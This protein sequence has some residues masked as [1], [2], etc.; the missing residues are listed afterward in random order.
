MPSRPGFKDPVAPS[1]SATMSA[2]VLRLRPRGTASADDRLALTICLAIIVHAM[3]VLGVSFSPTPRPDAGIETMDILLVSEQSAAAPKDADMLAQANLE[4]GGESESDTPPSAPLRAPLPSPVAAIAATPPPP[5]AARAAPAAEL[6][7]PAPPSPTAIPA[8]PVDA[9]TPV[10]SRVTRKTETATEAAAEE[11]REAPTAASPVPADVADSTIPA[12]PVDSIPLP[13]AAQLLTRSFALASVNA[14]L[15]QRLDSRAHRPRQKYISANTREYRYAAYMEAWRAKVERIGNINYP[16]EARERE[17]TG[18]LL[19]DVAL[20]PDGSVVE[21]TVRRSSGHE[22]LDDAAVRIVE[23]AAPYAPFP[24]D[25]RREVDVLHIT[26]TWKFLDT[27]QFS[28][29]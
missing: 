9:L 28:S 14:E 17:L 6:A 7:L 25:V 10:L 26:R 3:V 2:N 11:R 16:D 23:L 4:G 27:D 15:Q 29:R 24:D 18:A 8:P 21:I 13:S 22:V 19:L 20:N 5:V 12:P 1:M